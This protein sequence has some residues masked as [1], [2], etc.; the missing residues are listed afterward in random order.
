[1]I[2]IIATEKSWIEGTAVHQLEQI[3]TLDDIINVVGFPDLHAGPVGIA[4]T[5]A[6]KLYPHLIGSDIGCG[7]CFCQ[8][9]ALSRKVNLDKYVQRL[10][11]L[12]TPYDGASEPFFESAGIT[13]RFQSAIG[14]IGGG[15]HFAELQKVATIYNEALFNQAG[16]QKDSLAILVHSGSRTLGRSIIDRFSSENSVPDGVIALSPHGISYRAEH[17]Y[18]LQWGKVNRS[19]IVRRML[20]CLRIDG[21]IVSDTI[22]NSVTQEQ[23][24]NGNLWVHRKGASP[25]NKGITVIAGSRGALSYVVKPCDNAEHVNWSLAHGAGR[26]YRR[27]EMRDRL[28]A[29]YSPDALR[30]TEF[31]GRVICEDKELLYEEAPQAYKNIE[32]VISD[33]QNHGLIDIIASYQP[34]ITFKKG[35]DTWN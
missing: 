20:D 1:L 32:Q 15:N 8:T 26:K 33:L 35:V 24:T 9:D 3:H 13:P 27:N 29:R 12:D 17:D 10:T 19:L 18:A 11:G 28:H 14:T 25:S 7:M 2:T 21:T 30:Y 5:S 16:L 31:G 23:F 22:H 34:V 6:G 4:V